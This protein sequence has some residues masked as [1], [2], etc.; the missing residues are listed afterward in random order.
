MLTTLPCY[1]IGGSS[2]EYCALGLAQISVG[3]LKD[4]QYRSPLP[5]AIAVAS[6]SNVEKQ[7]HDQTNGEIGRLGRDAA[8]IKYGDWLV[9]TKPRLHQCRERVFLDCQLIQWCQEEVESRIE[10]PIANPVRRGPVVLPLGALVRGCPTLI[11][12]LEYGPLQR[13]WISGIYNTTCCVVV[14]SFDRRSILIV[15]CQPDFT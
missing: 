8:R 5:D 3:L 13:Y 15:D 12:V 9:S 11:V 1:P 2:G 10:Q 4:D 7:L 6:N 14:L